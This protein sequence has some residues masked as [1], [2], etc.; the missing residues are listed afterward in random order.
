MTDI[1]KISGLEFVMVRILAFSDF[2]TQP[3]EELAQF[4][5]NFEEP[6][7]VVVYGGDDVS[8]FGPL[9]L[10]ILKKMKLQPSSFP[11]GRGKIRSPQVEP[12]LEMARLHSELF[13][14]FAM[15]L[16]LLEHVFSSKE[17][18]STYSEKSALLY[19]AP[20]LK[21][22]IVH[23]VAEHIHK[24]AKSAEERKAI[25][26]LHELS[27]E[28]RREAIEKSQELHISR[29]VLRYV[30]EDI[31]REPSI[32]D[33]ASFLRRKALINTLSEEKE[34]ISCLIQIPE[35]MENLFDKLAGLT[36]NRLVGVLGNDDHSCWESLYRKK[37]FYIHEKP[38]VVYDYGFIGLSGA[39]IEPSPT[40]I[41]GY[42][43]EMALAH[44]EK[45][46]RIAKKNGAKKI[47]L[48]SHTPP[49]GVLDF[50]LRFGKHNIGSKAVREFVEKHEEVV[51]VLCGHSHLNGGKCEELNNALVVN[52]SSHDDEFSPGNVAYIT[53]GKKISVE[54]Y[55][56]P[57]LVES[58][59]TSVLPEQLKVTKL[60]GKTFLSEPEAN[61]I[62]GAY[63]SKDI[64]F[65]G[66][67]PTLYNIKMK[68]GFA[69]AHV[70]EMYKLGL[71]KENEITGEILDR[72]K[73]VAKPGLF[74]GV[75]YP[76]R[77]PPPSIL[78]RAYNRL[79][80][81][82]MKPKVFEIVSPMPEFSYP[83]KLFADLEYDLT[84]EAN[85]AAIYG[86]LDGVTNEFRQFLA[87]GEDEVAEYLSGKIREGY[88]IFHYGGSDNTLLAK[89][90]ARKMG[91][92]KYKLREY[93]T[94]VLYLLQTKSV[95][96]EGR[97]E[98]THVYFLTTP[99][100][101]HYAEKIKGWVFFEDKETGERRIE[102]IGDLNPKEVPA[103][104]MDFLT[105]FLGFW[106]PM[107]ATLAR[108]ILVAQ[109]KEKEKLAK[110]PEVKTLGKVN[111]CD[112]FA[113]KD[114]VEYIATRS[115]TLT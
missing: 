101:S 70:L 63:K 75:H 87:G 35:C 38:F 100:L 86:F 94:N 80:S 78:P 25:K 97:Y 12:C 36:D 72:I 1:L 11:R 54:W 105:Y 50:S 6:V 109:S 58:I 49:H 19:S 102:P 55:R 89:V 84:Y 41:L 7:D 104:D 4:V 47:V 108:R 3:L 13:P 28:E 9:P 17:F 20:H 73:K 40:P 77:P 43:E 53:L 67:L 2:R 76:W 91:L 33:T 85:H 61:L 5:K 83:R 42:R 16:S 103:Q 64:D 29:S 59:L 26:N 112:I 14:P 45:L 96:P 68:Y 65:L 107:K 82:R 113:L 114:L 106:G 95:V 56:V 98:L 79:L 93:F 18:T 81:E 115:N 99:R 21:K 44:L 51:L 23:E 48:V 74:K 62:L 30:C 92:P 60:V 34:Y 66:N 39:P 90:L 27:R 10:D 46:R 8:R 111:K 69:W 52:A 71:R 32:D 15:P 31:G 88:R 22:E 24:I 37:A 57:S 110:M